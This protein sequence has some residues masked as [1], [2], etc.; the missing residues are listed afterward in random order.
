MNKMSSEK[1]A[2]AGY[3]GMMS[4]KTLIVPGLLNKALAQSVRVGPRKL[5]TKVARSVQER[6]D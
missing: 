1:V 5:V 2:M 4:G 3:K 6:T